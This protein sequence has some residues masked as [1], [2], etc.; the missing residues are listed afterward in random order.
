M[1]HSCEHSHER[2]AGC[3]VLPWL[4]IIAN[5]RNTES[6][7]VS[8]VGWFISWVLGLRKGLNSAW[9]MPRAQSQS[10]KVRH[11]APETKLQV[12]RFCVYCTPS[13]PCDVVSP[14][15]CCCWLFATNWQT[16]VTIHNRLLLH[17]EQRA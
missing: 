16:P 13:L 10:G 7:Q 2:T 17:T 12:Y 15:L 4:H 8:G 9:I 1:S 6:V 3:P 14:S 11:E 5:V